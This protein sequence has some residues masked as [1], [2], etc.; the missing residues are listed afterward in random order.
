MAIQ[1]ELISIPFVQAGSSSCRRNEALDLAWGDVDL[2]KGQLYLGQPKSKTKVRRRFPVRAKLHRLLTEVA[3]EGGEEDRVFYRF[4]GKGSQISNRFKSLRNR[5]DELPSFLSPHALRHT[6][7]SHL[8]MQGVSLQV[9]AELMGHTLTKTTELY[10]HLVEGQLEA[11]V[12][13]LPY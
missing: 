8:L 3:Q 5:I 2:K 13:L 1:P 6:F 4:E 9:V 11:A 7:A 10:G 12:D